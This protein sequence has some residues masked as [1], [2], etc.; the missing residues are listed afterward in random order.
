MVVM[1]AG[2]SEGEM[3]EV[4]MLGSRVGRLVVVS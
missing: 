1:G 3:L 4:D 2:S